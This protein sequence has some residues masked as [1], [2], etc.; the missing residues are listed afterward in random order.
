MV[1][2]H[3]LT[4]L[5][6]PGRKSSHT[7]IGVCNWH[8]SNFGMPCRGGS[9]EVPKVKRHINSW[10]LPCTDVVSE[11]MSIRRREP[12]PKLCVLDGCG[13]PRLLGRFVILDLMSIQ[14]WMIIVLCNVFGI[15]MRC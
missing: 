15:I 12:R 7:D 9:F 4:D 11:G 14:G 6:S 10:S 8:N 13:K 3:T 2:C 1:V 5:K